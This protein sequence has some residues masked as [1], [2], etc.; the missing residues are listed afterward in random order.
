MT[1]ETKTAETN[2]NP[3]VVVVDMGAIKIPPALAKIFALPCDKELFS[4]ECSMVHWNERPETCFA[5]DFLIA[6]SFGLAAVVDT[7]KR[8]FSAWKDSYKY[9]T[10][11]AYTVNHLGWAAHA[12]GEKGAAL[13]EFYFYAFNK[14]DEYAVEKYSDAESNYFFA[15]LD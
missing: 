11:L 14:L 1:T 2:E 13:A 12:K 7:W 6:E 15:V 8:A 10:E 4:A 3:A 9:A 5:R